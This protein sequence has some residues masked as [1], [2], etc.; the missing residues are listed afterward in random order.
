MQTDWRGEYQNLT[1]FFQRV[2]ISHLVSC[3]HAHQL[4]VCLS[5]LAYASMPHK[6]WDEAFLTAV[7]L[8]NRL[9]SKVI[10]FQTHMEHLFGNSSDYSLLRIFGC[11]CWP[12][13]RPYNKHKLIFWSKQCAFIGYSSLHK[14]YRC[15]DISTGCIYISRDIVFDETVLPFASLHSNAGARLR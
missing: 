3:P 1:S 14:G 8:I 9:Q 2:G 5:L 13:L 10:R 12:Y 7:H 4:E 11:V 6:Y 15:L